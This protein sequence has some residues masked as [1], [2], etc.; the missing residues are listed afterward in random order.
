MLQRIATPAATAFIC[1]QAFTSQWL[2]QYIEP[3][4][5]RKG[6]AYLFNGLI[7][8]LFISYY[9]TCTLNPGW[10]AQN[11]DEKLLSSDEDA[12]NEHGIPLRQRWCRKCEAFKPPR[13]HHCKTCKRW[14]ITASGLVG[15]VP[16]LLLQVLRN[17]FVAF[18]L[19]L[20]LGRTIWS[21]AINMTTIE[22]W[23]VERHHAVLRRA[24]ALG[25]FLDAP[26]GS[27]VK[28][29]HQ[30]FPWDIGI[31]TNFCQGMGSRNPLVWF[32]PLASSPT[33]ESGL[34]F[35]HNEID[36]ERP[37]STA[38]EDC[39]DQPSIDPSK[40]WPPPD[41]DRLFRA[42]RRDLA[43][44]DG[45]TQ[46]LDPEAFRQRQAAD[47]AR[48]EDADGEYVVRRKPFHERLQTFA[49]QTEADSY[50]IDEDA[51]LSEDEEE[52]VDQIEHHGKLEG[53]ESWRNREGERLADFGVDEVAEFYDEDDVPLSELIKRRQ[54]M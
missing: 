19:S 12:I 51:V 2:F 9:R 5:L 30:E 10:L 29:E 45:F 20:L 31:W 8:C 1:F 39:T 16:E 49:K 53:E 14:I 4:P 40:P 46:S 22:S 41:P 47:L 15:V 13:A 43:A 26:D 33:A 54:R 23:E 25:G 34:T 3:G 24:R 18:G 36:G 44:G 11:W 32:W 7:L 48:F 42:V 37:D 17:S 38:T 27:K 6:D 35:K 21:L 52:G 50:E 28:I